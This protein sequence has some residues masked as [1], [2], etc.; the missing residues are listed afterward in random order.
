MFIAI[1]K[2]KFEELNDY[3]KSNL[4]KVDISGN[5]IEVYGNWYIYFIN[6]ASGLYYLSNRFNIRRISIDTFREVV[7]LLDG[8]H[9]SICELSQ[10]RNQIPISNAIWNSKCDVNKFL[11]MVLFDLLILRLE[12]SWND[13]NYYINKD[14][15]T[16]V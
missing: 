4:V 16:I 9:P 2:E 6:V 14:T 3:V 8:E 13:F 12:T 5:V 15:I 7:L 11:N 1:N 10:V